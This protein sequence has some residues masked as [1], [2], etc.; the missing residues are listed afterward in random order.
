[1]ACYVTGIAP[2][3]DI[4]QLETVAN[5]IA[6]IDHAKLTILTKSDRTYEHESSFLNFI[7]T[8]EPYLDSDAVGSLVSRGDSLL[9][10][11]TGTGVPGVGGANAQLTTSTNDRS[12]QHVGTLPIPE[13]EADNYNDAI[14]DGRAV[15]AYECDPSQQA[16]LEDAFRK[17]G[18]NK[19]K[20]F[21]G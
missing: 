12:P 18:V 15:L 20:T 21:V 17:A 10:G 5:A 8:T 14:E 16:T 19:V 1:M 11:G 2:T 4:A 7:H 9:T 13:D 6:G 3:N